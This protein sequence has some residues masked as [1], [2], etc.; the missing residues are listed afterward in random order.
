MW[1]AR[2]LSWF[3]ALPAKVRGWLY[4]GVLA[5][6]VLGAAYAAGRRDEHRNTQERAARA[7]R[8]VRERADDAARAAER[9]GAD[10]RLQSHR[11]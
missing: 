7:E 4:I 3:T 6:I 11:F 8:Q 1:I 9:D 5:L 10:S 2:A